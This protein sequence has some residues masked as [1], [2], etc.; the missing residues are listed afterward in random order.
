MMI[1][2]RRASATRACLMG[3]RRAIPNA[4]S[5]R[6]RTPRRRISIKLAASYNRVRSHRSPHLEHNPL[7]VRRCLQR[8]GNGF[9]S[10]AGPRLQNDTSVP[11]DHTDVGSF[12]ETS[13]PA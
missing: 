13:K 3:E 10:A 11:L 1:S 4:Q 9:W 8:G 5:L 12:I 2:N 7:T 6:A